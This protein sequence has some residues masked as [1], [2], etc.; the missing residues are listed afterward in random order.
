M[1]ANVGR[2]GRITRAGVTVVLL[3]VAFFTQ[4]W[5]LVLLSAAIALTAAIAHCPLY[6]L[7]GLSTV[8]GLRRDCGTER[9]NPTGR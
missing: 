5:P 3:A 1:T 7:Y 6:R 8:G 4:A 2:I 9:C